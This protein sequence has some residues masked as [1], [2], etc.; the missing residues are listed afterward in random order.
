MLA[1]EEKRGVQITVIRPLITVEHQR[2]H[3]T[4]YMIVLSIANLFM[5]ANLMFSICLY[6]NNNYKIRLYIRITYVKFMVAN[7]YTSSFNS[8]VLLIF[9]QCC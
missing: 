9:V 4:F 5:T 3:C 6:I 1:K 2:Q 7:Y 8:H